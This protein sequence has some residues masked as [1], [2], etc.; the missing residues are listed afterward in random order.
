M[1]ALIDEHTSCRASIAAL[2]KALSELEQKRYQIKEV[3]IQEG[4]QYG[5][6]ERV[7]RV[8]TVKQTDEGLVVWVE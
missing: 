7:A 6:W 2:R 8:R 3:R 1:P 5:I 4:D